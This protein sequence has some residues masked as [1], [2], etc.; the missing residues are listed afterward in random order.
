MPVPEAATAQLQLR[1]TGVTDVGLKRRH[2][3]DFIVVRDDLALYAVCDGAGGHDS[4]DVAA[5]TAARSMGS[6]LEQ[7]NE[8]SHGVPPF[9][10][11]GLA[12]D[13]RRLA[14][15]LHRANADVLSVSRAMGS[16]KGMGAVVVATLFS[17]AS[18]LVHVAH[19]GDSR[20]YRLRAGNLEQLTQDHSVINDVIEQRPDIEEEMLARLP[21]NAVTRALGVDE[22]LRVSTKSYEVVDGDRYLLCSDGL[23]G[24]VSASTIGQIL[25]KGVP[26]EETVA[27]LI[28]AA[29][30]GGAPD[31]VSAIV[32]DCV[33]PR[34]AALPITISHVE[35]SDES[36]DSQPELLILGVE[37]VSVEGTDVTNDEELARLLSGL[38]K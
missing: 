26:P 33:S 13:A 34:T 6:F 28:E 16:K 18:A 7:S 20:C 5:E 21:R 22:H 37:D 31:N 25:R 15:A 8:A 14:T 17:S 30:A 1:A 32:I 2:N 3:E 9:D 29:K 35:D 11:F 23:T 24:P 27:L 38:M 4:G 10:R 19:A 36:R 12:V